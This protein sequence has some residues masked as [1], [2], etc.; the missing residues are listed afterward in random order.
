MTFVVAQ[1]SLSSD[2]PDLQPQTG[3]ETEGEIPPDEEAL[4]P[5]GAEAKPSAAEAILQYFQWGKEFAVRKDF[6]LSTLW[7]LWDSDT[8]GIGETLFAFHW[9]FAPF[10]SIG[11][12][13]ELSGFF[14]KP[15]GFPQFAGISIQGGF[16]LP[17]T[18]T[19]KI[20]GDLVLELG[21]GR[22]S[23][24]PDSFFGFNIGYDLGFTYMRARDFGI[25]IKYKGFWTPDGRYQNALGFGWLWNFWL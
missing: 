25:E 3:V 12:G 7:F 11:G 14:R 8:Q 2:P 16:V 10:M 9:S 20:F 19:I 17:V 5:A 13:F 4:E 23:I 6:I 24:I 22:I 21:Y 15:G 1:D 18:K